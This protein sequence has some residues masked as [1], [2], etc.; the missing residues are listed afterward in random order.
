ML[1]V[2]KS[3][4]IPGRGGHGGGGAGGPSVGI[5]VAHGAEPEMQGLIFELGPA[6]TGGKSAGHRGSAG[7]RV[8]LWLAP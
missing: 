3:G 5:F 7:R 8:E 6:G 1:G 4:G 2:N